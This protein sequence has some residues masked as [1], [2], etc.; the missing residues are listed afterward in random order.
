MK[1]GPL[2]HVLEVDASAP[3]NKQLDCVGVVLPGSE[4]KVIILILVYVT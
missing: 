1:W 2:H 4:L 3:V